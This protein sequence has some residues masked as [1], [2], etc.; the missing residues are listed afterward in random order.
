MGRASCGFSHVLY[1]RVDDRIRELLE[2]HWERER[3]RRPGIAL[4]K[5]DL[6]REILLDAL[7]IEAPEQEAQL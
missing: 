6:V 4:S 7:E 5:A 2:R 1:V 3:S